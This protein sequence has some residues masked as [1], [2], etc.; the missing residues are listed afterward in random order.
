MIVSSYDFKI[1][2]TQGFF[3]PDNKLL[4]HLIQSQTWLKKLGVIFV[5]VDSC[6][7]KT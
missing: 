7:V 5:P 3:I 1:S 2:D 4:Y 6:I